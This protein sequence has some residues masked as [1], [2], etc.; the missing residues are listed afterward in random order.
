MAARLRSYKRRHNT[1]A[2]RYAAPSPSARPAAKTALRMRTAKKT[3]RVRDRLY[4]TACELFHRNGIRNVCVDLIASK[5][6]SNKMSF[7]RNFGS[8]EELVV[9]FLRGQVRDYWVWWDGA[10][11]P[12]AGD[13]RRQL[14]ALMEAYV[15]LGRQCSG[16]S[17]CALGNAAIELRDENH[18][19]FAIVRAYKAEMRERL[20]QLAKA[21]GARDPEQLGDALH[22]LMEGGY[23]TSLTFNGLDSPFA[24]TAAVAK[25]LLDAYQ[26]S[27]L[28]P[29]NAAV[30]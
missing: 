15:Q 13:P 7:Y 20:R 25:T 12:H 21:A 30:L 10:I 22:L 5:A 17:G 23:L 8:K 9:E 18:P 11:A 28:I 6:G 26:P 4:D 1:A 2:A 29:S 3:P 16:I 14:D 24:A 27:R 19:G